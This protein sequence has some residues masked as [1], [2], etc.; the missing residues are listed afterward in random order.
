MTDEWIE[1]YLEKRCHDLMEVFS[2]HLPGGNQGKDDKH[3]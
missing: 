1:K 2:S 3:Q